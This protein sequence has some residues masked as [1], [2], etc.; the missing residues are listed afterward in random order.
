MKKVKNP[1]IFG[2][3]FMYTL[4]IMALL[5]SIAVVFF[6]RQFSVIV[7]TSQREQITSNA[8][9]LAAR[10]SDRPAD[11]L[12]QIA[13]SSYEREPKFE[14]SLRRIN[15]DILYET[16]RF[17]FS[18][19][20]SSD[21]TTND[22]FNSF[23]VAG[24]VL[25]DDITL[26]ISYEVS[27]AAYSGFVKTTIYLFAVLMGVGIVCALVFARRMTSPI[28][29][30]ADDTREMSKLKCVTAPITRQD[31]IGE[32]ANDVYSM[33]ETLK[34]EIHK[35]KEMEENQRYFFSAASHELKTPVAAMSA[36]IEE[37]IE[38]V[39]DS[40][41]HPAYLRR[42]M[43]MIAEQ[44]KLISEILELVRLQDTQ[45]EPCPEP[46]VLGASIASLIPIYQP[47]A[48]AKGQ[49]ITLDIPESLS[50]SADRKQLDR[51]LSNILI[52][53]VE[54]SPNQ[55]QIQVWSEMCKDSNYLRLNICNSG[56][57]IDEAALPKLFEPFY[58][59]DTAWSRSQ[60]H[61]GLGLTIVKRTLDNMKL[62]YDLHNYENGVIFWLYLPVAE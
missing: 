18:S 24:I 35:V 16:P 28:K 56:T 38:G 22:R 26:Y 36:L 43:K 3:V 8:Q 5:V 39:A 11:E 53:A 32:L 60:G 54:N 62:A 7:E 10:L 34:S 2:K 4:L 30:L 15:N 55:A 31:E 27:Y 59:I 12:V 61:S 23:Q 42:C 6:A 49:S 45:I 25:V 21:P 51:V 33:Y 58:R 13:K 40:E 57:H 44:K 1:G 14:F 37:M 17:Q 41:D 19:N 52:N 48:E 47:L 9:L 20:T 29:K 50:C 46:F